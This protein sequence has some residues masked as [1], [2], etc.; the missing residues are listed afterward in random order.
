M[1]TRTAKYSLQILLGSI[2]EP[3]LGLL[4]CRIQEVSFY[5]E[6]LSF[7][8]KA[9]N[10]KT[11]HTIESNLLLPKFMGLEGSHLKILLFGLGSNRS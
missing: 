3:Q 9:F 5:M 2:L 4:G 1:K 8:H 6:D 7:V 10:W 11:N